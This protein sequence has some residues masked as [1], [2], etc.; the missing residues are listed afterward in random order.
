MFGALLGM[1]FKKQF[2]ERSEKTEMI[3]YTVLFAVSC[4]LT[5]VYKADVLLYG[6]GIYA[7]VRLLFAFTLWKMYDW[8]YKGQKVHPFEKR[9]F[10]VFAMH[11]NII[12]VI[13]KLIYLLL[14]K[15][16]IFVIPNMIVSL[17]STLLIINWFCVFMER[18]FPK[19]YSVISGS[20]SG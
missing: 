4:G 20:R 2:G 9:S 14:P 1:H 11:L 15:S 10:M 7:L 18:F 13:S 5:V 12:A 17:V 16:N 19:V 6:K 8:Y 3:I